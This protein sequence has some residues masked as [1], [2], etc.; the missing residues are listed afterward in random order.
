[1]TKI[2]KN[3]KGKGRESRR[4]PEGAEGAV[5]FPFFFAAA[6]GIHRE[7]HSGRRPWPCCPWRAGGRGL[8]CGC[9]GGGSY[10]LHIKGNGMRW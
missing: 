2:Q 5:V 6:R 8:H 4:E 3:S 7:A 9:R 1:M 10:I